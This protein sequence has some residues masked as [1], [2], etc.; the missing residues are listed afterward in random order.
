MLEFAASG[1]LGSL[2]GGLFRF[3]G[4]KRATTNGTD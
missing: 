3:V 2:F 1:L 4:N